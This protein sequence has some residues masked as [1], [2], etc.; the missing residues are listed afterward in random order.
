M[1]KIR[2]P[3]WARKFISR[4]RRRVPSTAEARLE[5]SPGQVGSLAHARGRLAHQKAQLAKWEGRLKFGQHGGL[6]LRQ[7]K[8]KVTEIGAK[9]PY[10][11]E[12]V[13]RL[14]AQE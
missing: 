11:E 8:D 1:K 4:H 14:E 3:V 12:E 13:A 10:W 6:T 2:A 9:V 7:M 5:G